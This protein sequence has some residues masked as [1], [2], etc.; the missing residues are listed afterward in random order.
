MLRVSNCFIKETWWWRW[1]W[2][3][4]WRRLDCIQH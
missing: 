4:N 1:W 2:A 3:F